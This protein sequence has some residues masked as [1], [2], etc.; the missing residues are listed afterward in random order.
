MSSCRDLDAAYLPFLSIGS[1]AAGPPD[2]LGEMHLSE[3]LPVLVLR[4]GGSNLWC[5]F[6]FGDT[7]KGAPEREVGRPG[8]AA[9]L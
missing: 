4:A 8:I 5:A 6:L 7:R 2:P 3:S 1:L 9:A